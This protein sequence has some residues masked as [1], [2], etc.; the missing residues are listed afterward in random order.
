MRTAADNALSAARETLGDSVDEGGAVVLFHDATYTFDSTGRAVFRRHWVYKVLKR[1]AVPEWSELELRWSP[2]HQALPTIEARVIGTDGRV[3]ELS[4]TGVEEKAERRGRPDDRPAGRADP[5][6]RRWLL[7]RLPDVVEG[8]LVEVVTQV[9]DLG[10]AF[11]AGVVQRHYF[12]MFVPVLDSRFTLD[13]SKRLPLRYTLRKLEGVDP[14]IHQTKDRFRLRL[15]TCNMPAAG[16]SPEGLPGYVPRYPHVSF[17]TGNDWQRVAS[18][19]QHLVERVLHPDLA[20]LDPEFGARL[21]AALADV[22]ADRAARGKVDVVLAAVRA[23]VRHDGSELEASPPGPRHLSETLARS[24]GNAVD[25]ATLT[26]AAL[27]RVGIRAHT[28]LLDA[29]FGVDAEAGLPG[30]GLFNH[31]VVY[32]PEQLTG[33]EPL[34]ELWID[35]G[36]P[37]ARAGELPLVDQGRSA[38]VAATSSTELVRLPTTTPDDN[39]ASEERRVILRDWGPGDLVEASRYAGSAEQTQRA[40][41]G[42]LDNAARRRGYLAYVRAFHGAA[43]LGQIKESPANDLDQRFQLR[44]EIQGAD[45]ATTDLEKAS[46]LIPVSELARRMPQIFRAPLDGSRQEEFIFHE[47]FATAWSY[48]VY[49]PDGFVAG[50]LPADEVLE[51]GPGTYRHAFRAERDQTTGNEIVRGTL[52]FSVGQRLL[53]ADQFERMHEAT[54]RFFERPP[55]EIEIVPRSERAAGPIQR[56]Q[57][58]AMMA[59]QDPESA[60]HRARLVPALLELG[61]VAEARS[62]ARQASDLAPGWPLGSWALGLALSYDGLGRFAGPGLDLEPARKRLRDAQRS[63]PDDPRL[64]DVLARL[65]SGSSGSDEH[66]LS[67]ATAQASEAETPGPAEDSASH[68]PDLSVLLPADFDVTSLH[69][70]DPKTPLFRL[71]ASLSRGG[72]LADELHPRESLRLQRSGTGEYLSRLSSLDRPADIDVNGAPHLGYRLDLEPGGGVGKIFITATGGD[73]RISA[74]DSAPAALGR[75]AVARLWEGDLTGAVQW[76]DWAYEESDRSSS[77][78]TSSFLRLWPP[79]KQV[80]VTAEEI[81]V[82]A[83]ALAATADLEGRGVEWLQ[84]AADRAEGIAPYGRSYSESQVRDR[85]QAA[86][87]ALVEALV[88]SGNQDEAAARLHRLSAEPGRDGRL[89]D[90]EI[91]LRVELED[92]RGVDQLVDAGEPADIRREPASALRARAALLSARGER[93][94]AAVLW[95]ALHERGELLDDDALRWTAMLL[96][97]GVAAASSDLRTLEA[98]IQ[99]TAAPKLLR[100][101]AALFA[102]F[103][104]E[105]DAHHLLLRAGGSEPYSATPAELFVKARTAESIGLVDTARRAYAELVAATGPGSDPEAV[106][107]EDDLLF[108]RLAQERLSRSSFG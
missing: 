36:A 84:A 7:A 57:G 72:E 50:D 13:V 42:G 21:D 22:P 3:S 60:A 62:Q 95:K 92:W 8:S 98:H 68:S 79:R 58:L 4:Q 77:R 70:E 66:T 34:A 108:R 33:G 54:L 30:L 41:T 85:Q 40:I 106:Q 87:V 104:R 71:L 6:R 73:L 53:T 83:A 61:L 49:P 27:R 43:G 44:L 48:F 107:D 75:E 99:L 76:L 88:S 93:G 55:L 12:V 18:R 1:S 17:S 39:L 56:A 29:G 101:V 96:A 9:R 90:L 14:E 64:K 86:G 24:E 89:R 51:L 31:V 25:L 5:D 69:P 45:S 23:R 67:T 35:P 15:R 19:Y 74:V 81:R 46:V 52:Y 63:A 59:A 37:F 97:P 2:W 100:R 16:A 32:V 10:P 82:A 105:V 20:Q 38:L 78:E 47:P 28:A 103:G 80:E 65:E 11:D 91:Q 26:I 102:A 94:E